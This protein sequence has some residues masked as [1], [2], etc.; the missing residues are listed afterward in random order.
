[1]A[2]VVQS[3]AAAELAAALGQISE[4]VTVNVGGNPKELTVTPFRLRQFAQVLKCVQR[5]YAGGV[6]KA[7]DLTAA[8]GEF[9]GAESA[10][11]ARA[12]AGRFNFINMLLLGGDEV[13]SILSIALGN[14]LQAQAL[15][16]LDLVDASRVVAA[17]F[18][19]NLDFFYQNR[20]ALQ[21]ALAPAV[22]AVEKIAEGAGALGLTGLTDSAGQDTP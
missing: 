1:M 16:G 4:T 7:E 20:D 2:T 9:T 17:V 12:T 11:A 14:Q 13:I 15:N 5:L 21:E 10:E 3:D 8:A 19:V 22:K 6:V 18:A